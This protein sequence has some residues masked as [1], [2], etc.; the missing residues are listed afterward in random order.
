MKQRYEYYRISNENVDLEYSNED[1]KGDWDLNR[2]M[3][4]KE[5]D[6]EGVD[7]YIFKEEENRI[8]LTCLD[9]EGNGFKSVLT[10]VA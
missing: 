6:E 7:F 2:K 1:F 4:K 5:R 10:R 8:E 9:P 3:M